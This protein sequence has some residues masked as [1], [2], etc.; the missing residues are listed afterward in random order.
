MSNKARKRHIRR[1]HYAVTLAQWGW[2]DGAYKTMA[3]LIKEMGLG[4]DSG[5][6]KEQEHFSE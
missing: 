6:T 3:S 1:M 5:E 2:R 4:G